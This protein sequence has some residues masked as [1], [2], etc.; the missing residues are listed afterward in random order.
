MT[1]PTFALSFVPEL[2]LESGCIAK[3]GL[4]IRRPLGSNVPK[5][6]NHNY[7]G[8]VPSQIPGFL[9]IPLIDL[10]PFSGGFCE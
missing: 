6:I 10:T 9:K 7:L 4:A 8:A 2:E 3:Q 1:A 5:W